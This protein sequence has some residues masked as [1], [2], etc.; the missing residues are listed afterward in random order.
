MDYNKTPLRVTRHQVNKG[1]KLN[2]ERDDTDT[3]QNLMEECERIY[4]SENING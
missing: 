1:M 2:R 3:E 4:P